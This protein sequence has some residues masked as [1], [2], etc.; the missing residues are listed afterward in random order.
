M[1]ELLGVT[2]TKQNYPKLRARIEIRQQSL[3]SGMTIPWLY[4]GKW[5]NLSADDIDTGKPRIRIF[6]DE[7]KVIKG[8]AGLVGRMLLD[9]I[10]DA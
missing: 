7:G 9:G 8:D 2:D 3:F 10:C 5:L 4:C 6:D 1:S